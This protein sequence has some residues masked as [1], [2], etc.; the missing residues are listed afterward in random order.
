MARRKNS[1]ELWRALQLLLPVVDVE[2]SAKARRPRVDDRATA[3]ASA[4]A[5]NFHS[6]PAR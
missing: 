1:N 4:D 6:R 3:H 2:P 5:Q